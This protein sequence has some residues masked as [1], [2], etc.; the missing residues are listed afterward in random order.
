MYT[1]AESALFGKQVYNYLSDREYTDLQWYLSNTPDSGDVIK[2]SGG[3]RKLRFSAKGKGKR[4]GVRVI[5]YL[6]NSIGEIWL[7]TI[8][9]KNED[10]TIPTDI[11]KKIREQFE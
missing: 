7:L 2:G 9:A 6:Q 3:I 11:L 5:Y 10:D 8:Y 4:S 1:F